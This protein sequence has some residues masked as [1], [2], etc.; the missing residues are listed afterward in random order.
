MSA[1]FNLKIA[2]KK[3]KNIIFYFMEINRQEAP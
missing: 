3:K 2:D 1:R